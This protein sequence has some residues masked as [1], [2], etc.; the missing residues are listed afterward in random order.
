M[1]TKYLTNYIFLAGLILLLLNDHL[2][3]DIYGN[4]FSGKL[5]DF[6]GVLILPLFLKSLFPISKKHAIGF[7]ILFF[8]FWKSPLSSGL[9]SGVNFIGFPIGRVVDYSDYLAFLVLPLSLYGLRYP[10]TI[11]WR[12]SGGLIKRLAGASLFV[13][14]LFAFMA[15]SYDEDYDQNP[16]DEC[17]EIDPYFTEVGMG[18]VYIPT[19]FT[20]D[21][22]GIN[23]YFQISADANIARI[24]TFLIRTEKPRDS[25]FYR[26]NITDIVP[27]NGFDG[28]VGDTILAALYQYYI[29]VT[30]NDGVTESFSG[31]VCCIPC[32]RP[33]NL[34]PPSFIDNCAY[35]VQYDPLNGYDP[36]IDSGETVECF[37]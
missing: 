34:P 12:M 14:S 7:T 17:C 13:I 36:S 24:D 26:T 28:V 27:Q 19:A 1:K 30:S 11:Q 22:N 20:P 8:L 6:A 3:K 29:V 32:A 23:D 31:T 16:F 37:D 5:S 18:K 25:I 9:I 35:P 4:W 10:D 21:N 2:L 33:L 15:T